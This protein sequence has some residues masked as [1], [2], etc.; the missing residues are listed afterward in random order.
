MRKPKTWTKG[1]EGTAWTVYT[2]LP[3]TG[4]YTSRTAGGRPGGMKGMEVFVDSAKRLR[5]NRG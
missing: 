1:N 2:N 4:T 3:T 5:L